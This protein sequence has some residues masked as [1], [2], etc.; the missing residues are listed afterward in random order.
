[1][2]TYVFASCRGNDFV[3]QGDAPEEAWKAL[4]QREMDNGNLWRCNDSYRN[5]FACENEGFLKL[6][7]N[8]S[9]PVFKEI[10]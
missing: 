4:V 8:Y 6:G 3:I 7:L 9:A 1:M 5:E 10:K 2:K